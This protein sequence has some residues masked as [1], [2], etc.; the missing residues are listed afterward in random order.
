MLHTP[1]CR[2]LGIRHP[3]F[4][5]PMAGG[6]TTPSLVS[7]VSNAGALGMLAGARVAPDQLRDDIRAVK[8]RTDRPFGVNFLLARPGEG[9]GDPTAVQRF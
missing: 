2:L 4:Q 7:E 9:N 6:W 3:I 5:A 1:L 8:A